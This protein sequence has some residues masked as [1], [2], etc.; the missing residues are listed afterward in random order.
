MRR[1][2]LNTGKTLET[3]DFAFNPNVNRQQ[4]YD[5]AAGHF[6]HEKRNVLLCGP[7]G[8]GKSHLAQALAHEACRRG[9]DV[10]FTDAHKMLR[11]LAGGRLDNTYQRR[12]ALFLRRMDDGRPAILLNR[13]LARWRWSR[14]YVE[15]IV[16]AELVYRRAE[17]RRAD[18]E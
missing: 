9:F 5:L 15:D 1:A 13:A 18:E 11:H 10:V 17:R 12:L 14:G 4:L 3:F 2:A 16:A 8:V 7:T 6:I